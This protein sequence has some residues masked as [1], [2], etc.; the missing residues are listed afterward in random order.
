MRHHPIGPVRVPTEPLVSSTRLAMIILICAESMLFAGFVGAYLVFRLKAQEWPPV[1]QPRLPVLV[2][3]L[4]TL[5]LLGSA[6]P[7]TLALRAVRRPHAPELARLL[8]TTAGLGA[9]FLVVQ[10]GE[11]VQLVAHGLTLGSSVYGGGFYLLIGCHALH[12]LTALGWL[13][14]VAARASRGAFSPARFA[15]VEMCAMYWYF[16]CGLWAGLFPLVY[17]Y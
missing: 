15:G 5:V 17:L 4:N 13:V 10:G 1:N 12:V 9:V 11:W 16:V 2:T 7:L 3:A 6:W 14:T 8:W